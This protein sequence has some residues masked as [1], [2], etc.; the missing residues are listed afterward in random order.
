MWTEQLGRRGFVGMQ[1]VRGACA[2]C[3]CVCVC[4]LVRARCL[5][6]CAGQCVQLWGEVEDGVYCVIMKVLGCCIT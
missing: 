4:E 5:C 1:L 3:V 6:G 2:E